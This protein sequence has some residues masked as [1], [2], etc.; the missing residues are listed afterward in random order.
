MCCDVDTL[1]M[2][3]PIDGSKYGR[4]YAYVENA[5]LTCSFNLRQ[6]G[7]YEIRDWKKADI[8]IYII[9]QYFRQLQAVTRLWDMSST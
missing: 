8:Y 4:I 7:K 1:M 6:Y 5:A 9:S 3:G 2:G